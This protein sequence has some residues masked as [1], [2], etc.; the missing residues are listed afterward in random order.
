MFNRIKPIISEG[1][2][3]SLKVI[4]QSEPDRI[5]IQYGEKGHIYIIHTPEGIVVDV[6]DD[7]QNNLVD[8]FTIWDDDFE[9]NSVY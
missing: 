8:T 2:T 9:V 7:S 3:N 4:D 1:I 5:Q 6:F